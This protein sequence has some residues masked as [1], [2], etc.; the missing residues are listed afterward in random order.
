MM[1]LHPPR[2]RGRQLGAN[3]LFGFL[4]T[5]GLCLLLAGIAQAQV[6]TTL[7]QASN[8]TPDA[9]ISAVDW[10]TTTITPQRGHFVEGSS[11]PYRLVFETLLPGAHR[12]VIAWD[13]RN[14]GRH[15]TDY[16]THFN[17]LQPHNQF[18]AHSVPE[19]IQPLR[20][21]SGGP[22]GPSTFPIP[23]PNRPASSFHA[24]PANQRNFHIYNGTITGAAYLTEGSVANPAAESRMAI[25][26]VVN[27]TPVLILF[28]GHLAAKQEWGMGQTMA[29][30]PDASYRMRLVESDGLP[31][32]QN[33]AVNATAVVSS[34]SC[35][36][37][38]PDPVCP[39]TTNSYA[40]TTDASGASFSWSLT[41][42]TSGASI[43]GPNVGPIVQVRAGTGGGTYTLQVAITQGALNSVCNYRVTVLTST[44][45]TPLANASACPGGSAMFSTEPSGTGPFS[46]LWRKG[47]SGL[48]GETS[49]ILLL[50][51]VAQA[52][53][54]VYC[55][56]VIGACNYV[57]HC[58]VLTVLTNTAATAL[59]NLGRCVGDSAVFA[60]L[61][62]GAGPFTY[63]W[64]KNGAEIF[65]QTNRILSI[66]S[67][68]FS[69]T[70]TYTVEV[71][72]LCSSVTNSGTL[73]VFGLPVCGVQGTNLVCPLSSG[74]VYT[75]PP[76]MAAYRWRVTGNGTIAGPT[77]QQ[78]VMVESGGPGFLTL[79]LTVVNSNGCSRS[80]SKTV[81]VGD[82]QPPVI[83]CPEKIETN[84]APGQCARV[85]DFAV[86]A[87]DDCD[88]AT[89][90][91]NPPAG[92]QFLKGTTTVNCTAT[93][94][95]GNQTGCAFN[96]T[97][98]DLEKPTLVCPTNMVVDT[99]A[100]VCDARVNYQVTVVDNCPGTSLSCTPPS[101]TI[102]PLG[103]SSVMC[104]GSDASGNLEACSFNVTVLDREA[105][106]IICPADQTHMAD[107][108]QCDL[109]V[110]YEV[111]AMENCGTSMIACTP[112]SGSVFPKGIT[113]VTCVAT[114]TSNNQ[115]QCSFQV[116]VDDGE[117]P[118]ITCPGDIGVGTEAGRCDAVVNYVLKV[119]DNCPG[120]TTACSPP[121]GARFLLGQTS[122]TCTATDAS[123][124][125]ASCTFK[126]TVWDIE[127]PVLT[128]PGD[129][130]VN[131]ETGR[132][133]AVI[134][135]VADGTD[136]CP[137][138]R[139]EC[140]P[141]AGSVFT[142]GTTVVNCWAI[143]ASSNAVSCAFNV[144]VQDTQVPVL[145]CPGDVTTNSAPG[146]CS[147][148]VA[149]AVSATDNC[150]GVE[151]FCEPA[152]GS[153][154][155]A[156]EN[157]VYCVG[158]DASGNAEA[159][160]FFVNVNDVES[161]VVHCPGDLI[162]DTEPGVC[163]AHVAFTAMVTDN[164]PGAT[165]TCAPPS[166]ST[167]AVGTNVV[168][169]TARDISGNTTQCA[170]NV[171]VSDRESPVI[172]CATDRVVTTA[173][174][175]CDAVVSYPVSLT[176]NCP[177][178]TVLCNPPSGSTFVRGTNAVNCIAT[179]ASGNNSGCAFRVIVE[180]RQAPTL[181]CPANII[182]N[183]AA[184]RCD[185]LITFAPVVSDN[186]ANV[187]LVCVPPSGS[188]FALGL[189][190][191][192]CVATDASGNT[193]RCTFFVAVSDDE[194]P[195]IACPANLT[196]P[197]EPGQCDARVTFSVSA[198]DNCALQSTTCAPAS[199]TRFAKGITP[200]VC[201]AR[202]SSGNQKTCSFTVAV[203]D[204]EPPALLCPTNQSVTTAAGG[205]D[206]VV[207]FA[208]S[209]SDNCAGAALV[210]APPP[211]TRFPVGQSP[212]T[213][214]AT[215]ASGNTNRCTFLVIVNDL[216]QP[217]IVCPDNL[218]TSTQAG[219]C[220]AA[221]TFGTTVTDNCPGVNFV[222][223]PPSGSRFDR[224]ATVVS[225]T[226]TDASGNSAACAFTITVNDTEPPVLTCPPNM[227]VN[228]AAGRCDAPV[229]Y[230]VAMADNCP[231]A[232]LLCEPPS[233]A[234]FAKG[235][236]AVN[237]VGTDASGNT[238]R[239]TF[240]VT[241]V[242]RE[243]PVLACPQPQELFTS[244]GQCDAVA[245]FAA[246]ATDNCAG[247]TETCAPP[248]GSRFATG[249]TAVTCTATDASGNTESCSFTITV[250]DV[251]PPVLT[252]PANIVVGADPGRCDALV[253]FAPSAAD[254]CAGVTVVCVPASGSSFARGTTLVSCTATDA[255]SNSVSCGFSVRVED[256]ERPLLVCPTN[257]V[258]NAD[259]G[260]C[261][262]MVT[263]APTVTDNCP[264]ADVFCD[265]PSG[266]VLP[267]GTNAVTCLGL[268]ASGNDQTCT[269]SVV[270]VDNEKPIIMC[271]GNISLNTDP[272]RCDARATFAP[273]VFDNC[274]TVSTSCV[275]PSGSQFTK[276]VATVICTAT[277]ANGNTETCSFT[278]TVSDNEPP[279]VTCPQTILLTTEPGM[280]SARA[281]F[282][283]QVTDNCPGASVQ[284]VPSSGSE[285]PLG[286]TSVVCQGTDAA[287]NTRLCAFDLRV[288]D[289]EPPRLI[290]PGDLTFNTDPTQCTARVSYA[291]SGDDPCGLTNLVCSPPSGSL[292][293]KGLT[294]VHCTANDAS[295]NEA[296]CAFNLNVRDAE[297]PTLLCPTNM[298]VSAD[299]GRCN[300][301]VAFAPAFSDNC[302]GAS[303]VCSPASGSFFALGTTPVI[304][305]ATDAAGNTNQCSF[306]VRVIDTEKPVVLCSGNLLVNC[307]TNRCD[308]IVG[309]AASA[310]D[311][312]GS[313]SPICSPPSGTRFLL[314]ATPVVCT[315]TDAA[316]NVG[317]CSFSVTVR[318]AQSP[319]LQCPA[320]MALS[321]TAGRCDATANFNVPA[322]D[323]CGSV[324]VSCSPPSGSLFPIGATTVTCTAQDA[325]SNSSQ[326]QFTVTVRDL[327]PPALQ[328]PADLL[329]NCLTNR[330]D[331]VVSFAPQ[332]S[333]N[334]SGVNLTCAPASGTTFPKGTNAVTC[335]A[336]DASSN[337]VNCTF[338]VVV[339]DAEQPR[340]FCPGDLVV[341]TT[342]DQCR[343]RVT[344][345]ATVAD[346][347]PG[348]TVVCAPPSAS[349]FN[350]GVTTV[351]C[352]ATDAAGNTNRC[353]FSVTVNDTVPPIITCP[354][355]I[356]TNAALGQVSTPVA[357]APVVTDN[358]PGVSYVC[359]PQSGSVFSQGST[360]VTCTATD[361]AGNTRNCSFTV[362]VND[363]EPPVIHCPTN[364]IVATTVGR[365]D[366]VANYT[367]TASDNSQGVTV[368]CNP[369]KGSSLPK[370]LTNVLCTAT[371]ASNNRASCAFSIT[372]IDLERPVIACPTNVVATTERGRCDARA[373]YSASATDNCGIPSL[374]CNPPSG[375]TLP[376]GTNTVTCTA[377]DAAGN[378]ESCSFA[379]SV[380][381]K[382][383]PSIGCPAN[384]V[385]FTPF[386]Q[387]DAQVTYNASAL[388][389]CPGVTLLCVP[390]SGSS[391]T[392]GVTQVN[393][394]ARDTSG[395]TAACSFLVDVRDLESPV[396]TC[397]A[398]L[399]TISYPGLCSA[400]I[401]Y[402][403]SVRDN[404]PG[405]T[406]VCNPPSGSQMP[407]GTNSVSCIG[408][409]TS[410]NTAACSFRVIIRD[411]E[412]PGLTCPA[413][414]VLDGTSGNCT[415]VATYSP[416]VTDN[417]PGVSMNCFPPSGTSFPQGTNRVQC[418]ALD[419]TGNTAACAFN[420]IV[421]LLPVTATPLQ[422]Q[423]ACA[424]DTVSF[425]TTP[426]G[427]GPF[428][429]TWTK[430]DAVIPGQ[431]GPSLTL[432]K[433][434]AA[435]AG[436]YAVEVRG[437]CSGVTNLA[438]LAVNSP[439][440]ISG[441]TNVTRCDCDP[442]V[443]SPV[444][445]GTGPLSYLW[446]K[447]GSVLPGATSDTLAFPKLGTNDTGVY[448]L[449]VSGACNTASRSAAI[450]VIKVPNPAVYTNSGT[451]TINDLAPAFPYPSSV[452]VT[453]VPRLISRATVTLRGFTHAYPDDVDVL[454]AGP[455]GQSVILMSDAGDGS[456]ANNIN[457]T[458]DDAAASALPD[459]TQLF[460]GAFR[461]GNYEDETDGF[462]LPAPKLP[463]AK[464]L[465]TLAGTDANGFWSLFVTDDF[466]LDAGTLANGWVLRLYWE[467]TPVRLSEP[468]ML[469][470]GA[471]QMTLTGDPQNTY[472]IEASTDLQ[473]WTPIATITLTAPQADFTDPT[474]SPAR[475]YRA[476][477][478]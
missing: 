457:I 48:A 158:V 403:A 161:P 317:N 372:V 28:G 213:C 461:P 218:T 335:T 24:L 91:C 468:R 453:C 105:P 380:L 199:G 16:L 249:V 343:A 454:L 115:S 165:V 325:H 215:D 299:D 349:F 193:N 346:N 191:V 262:A 69:D 116:R 456:F 428:T 478:P 126:V 70:G 128:C 333:D 274:S 228:T 129:L 332:A 235:P 265:P 171:T 455:Y 377:T 438:T 408:T 243:K 412:R 414:V 224:G 110:D 268:D 178:A 475:F 122:V 263:F 137:G 223:M 246:S 378:V 9:P 25:D 145:V 398:D 59:Q 33:L 231:G 230:A 42:N 450:A 175:R 270:V 425:G 92:A 84:T 326:C 288:I 52:S 169:C 180:D 233:G 103:T 432:S 35:D 83:A 312:C 57:T 433:V 66:P 234:T 338:K 99:E 376:K 368:V 460:T 309:F 242:D 394:T 157:F 420:V 328:C 291:V 385:A 413:D 19:T 295:G 196:V 179:D 80:C 18:G 399:D 71:A 26:F 34:P 40:A 20:D 316:G 163:E 78:A 311:N 15:A 86:T 125:S 330:C 477:Q 307:E 226:A 257:L 190:T 46:F 220:D 462:P 253:T 276:G 400:P 259:P 232:A 358:C 409:D 443:L 345:S 107:P 421:R 284:C 470:N 186:C 340:I 192:T 144:V 153:L 104:R 61:A 318:D 319:V 219:R 2:T 341:S 111:Q 152:S 181:T 225:C 419:R 364:L 292:F 185:A 392:R 77:N 261:D 172:S 322:T 388:D 239:C 393:C 301:S 446:R 38:G 264:G 440:I 352:V 359:S 72:G 10:V 31:S 162:L 134:Q 423:T 458:L 97:V 251:E 297:R 160:W 267:I 381:D 391:F 437:P 174:G 209:Y 269:F 136:N 289:T 203:N 435:D 22:Q 124:N 131:A 108:G 434:T 365:C 109:V 323:N 390:A 151:L 351:V 375:A 395:S 156:G 302:S 168:T 50:T 237:C 194:P 184:G 383:L 143:D 221:V 74:H 114:D 140:V 465:S 459:Q 62:S 422:S 350:K 119:S 79:Q 3:G 260:W 123:G 55:V 397:P 17:R 357:F 183:T 139:V 245:A 406:L 471:C 452:R 401:F 81:N 47:G 23:A 201:T 58:A 43:V 418:T 473:T 250:R 386:G 88:G 466:Q 252:C 331:A 217:G 444:V 154:F 112:P 222:C 90:V 424:A 407:V 416:T 282:S 431:T 369:P 300:A 229:S 405:A 467:S 354:A 379:V 138:V 189:T 67:V 294:A 227:A 207:T 101:G 281:E 216:E 436:T 315:A 361:A 321:A 308:A 439:V 135:Y 387:C 290:C 277:D 463:Y 241:V 32:F 204:T 197:T 472:T 339:R 148:A 285:F 155:P 6:G 85:V 205:C 21:I 198:S 39:R 147:A 404:C 447:N 56:E 82:N 53:A 149:Y 4:R 266:S 127:R 329:V 327:D 141:P 89:V 271:A 208:P 146:Q 36:I 384:I 348:A 476:T 305:T 286:T 182:T 176:D 167:F 132:C 320:N 337:S 41:E 14:N 279:V 382:E 373:T 7:E 106:Q 324:G 133:D 427:S 469:P 100:S 45:A 389:N 287:G 37:A 102:F 355:N 247:T 441:L 113:V 240:T 27:D 211:G 5:G 275:P 150:P 417:C 64:R 8:G 396:V 448:T 296:T 313:L 44:S 304:C 49:N 449:E 96:V 238:N 273:D 336:R 258:I 13:T 236:T 65:G 374:T 344:F 254:D 371:D 314:G 360:L 356:S 95:A 255:S 120:V 177:G 73:M 195:V 210:C 272:A 464:T 54:G 206:A 170:F 98:A 306:T 410:G 117:K 442:L 411:L 363:N 200:V 474:P 353:S 248:S 334:C 60:T 87:T 76:N 293:A 244:L 188:S 342:N 1:M 29:G 12:A 164:C 278:V 159:C 166:G 173:P 93:D 63:R 256:R 214:T 94:N 367:V 445:S 415:S 366:A 310:N 212:V 187:G 429:F 430:Y 118:R 451:I 11:V 283:A 402:N 75:A 51:N 130:L 362:T 68:A 426:A 30:V 298:I 142:V 121:L 280:C 303:V 370:G 202:D 347:C